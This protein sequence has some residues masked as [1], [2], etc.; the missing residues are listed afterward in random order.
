MP[1]PSRMFDFISGLPSGIDDDVFNLE[2][3]MVMKM[4]KEMVRI[5][6]ER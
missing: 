3:M 2:G 1:R 4:E 5:L 6:S